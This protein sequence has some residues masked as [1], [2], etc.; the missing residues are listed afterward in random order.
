MLLLGLGTGPGRLPEFEGKKICVSLEQNV[1]SQ[2][3]DKSQSVHH[4]AVPLS[5]CLGL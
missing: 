1:S 2:S 4:E 5:E 3:G